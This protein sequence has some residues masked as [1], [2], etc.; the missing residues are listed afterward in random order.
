MKEEGTEIA[1]L[2]ISSDGSHILIGQLVEETEGAKYW[3]LYMNVGD[4]GRNDRP[5]PRQPPKASSSTG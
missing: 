2:D 5:H 4:S 3:H 1:E